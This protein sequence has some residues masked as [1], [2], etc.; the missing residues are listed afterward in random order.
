MSPRIGTLS[1]TFFTSS[2][3]N[4]PMMIVAPSQ[5]VTRVLTYRT[6]KIGW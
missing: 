1:S 2:R 3:V 5:M 4:P 6:E